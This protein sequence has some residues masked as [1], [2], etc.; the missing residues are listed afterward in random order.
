VWIFQDGHFTDLL[1]FTPVGLEPGNLVLMFCIVFGLSMDYEVLLLSRMHEAYLETGDNRKAVQRGLASSGRII[2]GA[3]L[4]MV[5]VFG[6]FGTVRI[7]FM[8]IIGIGLAFAILFDATVIRALLV[9]ALMRMMGRLN[10]YAPRWM[11]P[12]QP[13]AAAAGVAA[14]PSLP[15]RAPAPTKAAA[16]PGAYAGVVRPR[17]A[18]PAVAAWHDD[19]RGPA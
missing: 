16:K 13:V 4:I 18:D 1:H 17:F 5:F 11:R 19:E 12:A 15:S 10:W 9:P 3:A 7:T 8:K 14:A 2:T 6:A